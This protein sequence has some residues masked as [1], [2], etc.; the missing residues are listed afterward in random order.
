MHEAQTKDDP[1][2]PPPN[3][4]PTWLVSFA[5]TPAGAGPAGP[6]GAARSLYFG[7]ATALDPRCS[8][9]PCKRARQRRSA[10]TSRTARGRTDIP[11]S[12]AFG[13]GHADHS[14]H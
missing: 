8:Q 1:N 7:A 5:H 9:A 3:H 12:T 13:H 4:S 10:C 2:A 6:D 11:G 14:A